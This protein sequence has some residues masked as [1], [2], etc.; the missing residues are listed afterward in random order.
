MKLCSDC[1]VRKR[2]PRSY[3]GT[4]CR[5]CARARDQIRIEQSRRWIDAFARRWR[6][7]AGNVI[8]SAS[9]FVQGGHDRPPHKYY[10]LRH[11]AIMA[12]GGYRCG[13]CGETEPMFLTLDHINGGGSRHRGRVGFGNS[14]LKWLR[15]RGYPKGFRVLCWNC[16]AGRHRNGGECPHRKGKKRRAKLI[17]PSSRA[18]GSR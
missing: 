2:A 18:H 13:C 3:E 15:K 6:R 16:N 1:G 12:Y 7:S 5:I 11:E 4:T 17:A 9:K 10:R 8:G 14:M